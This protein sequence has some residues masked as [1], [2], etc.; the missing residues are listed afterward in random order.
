MCSARIESFQFPQDLLEMVPELILSG[1][2]ST[3]FTLCLLQGEGPVRNGFP[4]SAIAA[5]KSLGGHDLI[6]WPLG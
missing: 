2:V 4:R 6:Q 1:L 5:C 3:Q